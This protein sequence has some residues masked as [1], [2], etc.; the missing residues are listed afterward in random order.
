MTNT[1]AYVGGNPI[2]W[3]DPKGLDIYTVHIS[4][5]IPLTGGFDI[6]FLYNTGSGEANGLRDIGI[7]SSISK[8][9]SGAG[10]FKSTLGVAQ[11]LGGRCNFD[12]TGSELKV[13]GGDIGASAGGFDS[14]NNPTSL[15][16]SFGP[17]LGIEAV[18]TQTSSLT[19]GDLARGLA[20]LIY[21]H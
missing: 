8:N 20:N 13:G 1:Y 12:G 10:L 6:G 14:N 9:V 3:V 11:S 18:M 21:G 5:H 4:V 15:K 16:F 17:Q 7:F 19:I 2:R